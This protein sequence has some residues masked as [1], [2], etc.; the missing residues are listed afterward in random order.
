MQVHKYIQKEHKNIKS[1]L[2]FVLLVLGAPQLNF[3]LLEVKVVFIIPSRRYSK[4]A[5]K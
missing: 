1:H 5:F 2:H 4:T 3:S